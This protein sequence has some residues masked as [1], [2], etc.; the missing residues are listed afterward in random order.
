MTPEMQEKLA[1]IVKDI[2]EAAANLRFAASGAVDY[3][4]MRDEALRLKTD[5]A[6]ILR[7]LDYE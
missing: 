5:A 7:L 4:G 1:R 6:D 2:H 3:A